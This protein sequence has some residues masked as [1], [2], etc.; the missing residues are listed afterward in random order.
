MQLTPSIPRPA[1]LQTVITFFA[2][3][4]LLVAYLLVMHALVDRSI[5]ENKQDASDRDL[6]Y[7]YVHVGL[8]AGATAVGFL[9]GKWF[10][11]LGFAFAALFLVATV[12]GVTAVQI[13]SYELACHGHNDLVRH[14]QC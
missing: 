8:F 11:G 10:S 14:W 13:G 5:V 12:L 9:A 1:W 2:L 4:V 3:A 6:I 7:A